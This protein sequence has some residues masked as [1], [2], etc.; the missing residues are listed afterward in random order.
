MKYIV[1]LCDGM[2]GYPIESLD[3]R[4]TMAVA[5]KPNMDKLSKVSIMGMVKTVPDEMAPGSD[6]ANLGAMGFNPLECYTGRSPLEAV[7]MGIKMKENDIAFRCNLVTLTSEEDYN[8]KT[9]ADYSAQ[10]ITTEEARELILAISE[11]IKEKNLEFYS[12]VSY[13]HCMI[14]HG[15]PKSLNLIPPHDISDRVIG[16]YLPKTEKLKEIMKKSY[17]ILKDHPVNKKR[18]EKGLNPANSLWIWGEGTKPEVPDFYETFGL[19][20]AVISAVDLVKGIG[21]A[22][23][24]SV[25]D[26]E[27]A[28]GNINTDFDNKCK[29][30]YEV[31]KNGSDYVYIHI[32]APDECGHRGETENKIKSIELIDEKVVGPLIEKLK[33][34]GENFKMLIMPDHPT[35]IETKTHSREEVPFMIFDSTKEEKGLEGFSESKA[36]STEVYFESGETLAK[37]FIQK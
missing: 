24:M 30:A 22:A 4:T 21:M 7:S 36:K 3:K 37:F 5:N 28:T 1:V 27:G 25:I 16:E 31:L 19:K 15:G 11:A 34:D 29:A 23:G 17:D 12:G 18:I 13:R 8:K 33:A 26:V 2:A 32:E 20:G 35:P 10:E 14:W 9:M 6:V